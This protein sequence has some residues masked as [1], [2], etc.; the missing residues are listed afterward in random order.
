MRNPRQ[1]LPHRRQLLTLKQGIPLT[2][3][4]R[5][6][7]LPLGNVTGN[8][9]DP[10]DAPLMVAVRSLGRQKG[11]CL[12]EDDAGLFIVPCFSG[13]EYLAVMLQDLANRFGSKELDRKSTR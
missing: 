4:L 5:F 8:A 7:L 12:A 9:N 13:G 3:E 10:D 11:A 2:L 1:Q 6:G